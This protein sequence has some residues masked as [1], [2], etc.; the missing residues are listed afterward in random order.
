MILMFDWSNGEICDSFEIWIWMHFVRV[1]RAEL[2]GPSLPNVNQTTLHC[3]YIYTTNDKQLNIIPSHFPMSI[4]LHH[5]YIMIDHW[6]LKYTEVQSQSPTLS[7]NLNILKG[8]VRRFF[9]WPKVFI[10]L[11]LRQGS[12]GIFHRKALKWVKNQAKGSKIHEI[13][14]KQPIQANSYCRNPPIQVNSYCRNP[15]I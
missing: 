13:R 5:I 11:K 10:G 4:E 7:N 15:P 3:N 9:Y 6:R 14:T 8:E 12:K 2:I 1:T